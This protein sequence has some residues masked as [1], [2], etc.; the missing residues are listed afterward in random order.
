MPD[1]TSNRSPRKRLSAYATLAVLILAFLCLFNGWSDVVFRPWAKS[2]TGAPLLMD[3]WV[4]QVPMPGAAARPIVL[5]LIRAPQSLARG[6][7][8]GCARIEGTAKVCI[9]GAA[10]QTF[11]I[12][13]DVSDWRGG[14]FQLNAAAPPRSPGTYTNFG[15]I[16]G[17]WDLADVIRLRTTPYRWSKV[18]QWPVVLA[19]VRS[20]ACGA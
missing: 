15:E 3:K 16:K 8:T 17:E 2:I 5:E 12:L 18:Q 14:K 19:P 10:A 6:T 1:T 13:R 20:W 4:G 7:C 9:P 11:S